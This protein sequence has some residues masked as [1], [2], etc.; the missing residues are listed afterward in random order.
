MKIRAVLADDHQLVRD[1]LKML[2]KADPDIDVIGEAGDGRDAVRQVKAL[3]PD[4]VILDVA[5]PEMNGLEAAALIHDTAPNVQIIVLS[6]YSSKE[7]IYRALR[8]GASG[9][10][11]KESAAAEMLACVREVAAKRRY[12]SRRI[13]EEIAQ[14]FLFP[15]EAHAI[16]TPLESLSGRERQVLQLV[17]EGKTSVQI[18]AT[19]HLSPKTIDTYRSRLMAKLGVRDIAELVRF[20]VQ[21][22][23]L[24][25]S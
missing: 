18:A 12:V 7:H 8:A 2:L 1:G 17:A 15:D 5:M 19:L 25:A 14:M 13:P 16:D 6:M 4:L 21:Q 9:Y 22:N 23:I 3:S 20:A 24:P 11:L 10:L